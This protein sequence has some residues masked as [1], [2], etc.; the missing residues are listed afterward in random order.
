M[1]PAFGPVSDW[2]CSFGVYSPYPFFRFRA[3][4]QGIR[5]PLFGLS[6]LSLAARSHRSDSDGREHD[7]EQTGLAFTLYTYIV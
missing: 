2:A 1:P 7:H 4:R 3:F 6:S 5:H